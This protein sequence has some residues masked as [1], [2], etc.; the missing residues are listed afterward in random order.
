MQANQ[1]VQA[2]TQAS[3]EIINMPGVTPQAFTYR[4]EQY[5]A[6]A[7]AF[8]NSFNAATG[9]TNEV[10]EKAAIEETI[11]KLKA[12]SDALV[13]RLSQIAEKASVKLGVDDLKKLFDSGVT[14]IDV[15]MAALTGHMPVQATAS[16][17][18]KRKS[19]P[20]AK[21]QKVY[22]HLA[23]PDHNDY[24]WGYTDSLRGLTEDTHPWAKKVGKKPDPNAFRKSTP[25]QL[26][27]MQS[28]RDADIARIDAQRKARA[29]Q[30]AQQAT[31][32]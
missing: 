2:V 28:R 10:E 27:E 22:E 17:S 9:A 24:K 20:Y 30:Q 15:L 4:P 8:G 13:N 12:L 29:A 5:D 25:E 19:D 16:G 1:L 6:A 14:D 31:N 7:L 23:Y 21:A 11:A 3:P 18:G 32:P 26:A